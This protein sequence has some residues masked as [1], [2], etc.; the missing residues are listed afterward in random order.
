MIGCTVITMISQIDIAADTSPVVVWISIQT[1]LVLNGLPTFLS[2]MNEFMSSS[3]DCCSMNRRI[4]LKIKIYFSFCENILALHH[5]KLNQIISDYLQL[6]VQEIQSYKEEHTED[7][8]DN[9]K[10][11]IIHI[12][13]ETA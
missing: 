13:E 11:S 4:E 7:Q 2:S 12:G 1:L 8:E 6:E 5:Q 3:K 9:V 10:R